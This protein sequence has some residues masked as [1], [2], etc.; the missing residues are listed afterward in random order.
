MVVVAAG[1]LFYILNNKNKAVK[2]AAPKPVA[3]A[4]RDTSTKAVTPAPEKKPAAPAPA[5]TCS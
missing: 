4:K 3:V 1:V 5:F 2:T